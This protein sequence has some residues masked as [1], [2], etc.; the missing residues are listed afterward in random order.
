MKQLSG[1]FL[2]LRSL[3]P[4]TIDNFLCTI[5]FGVSVIFGDCS[6]RVLEMYCSCIRVT[7]LFFIIFFARQSAWL[8]CLGCT[9]VG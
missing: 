6:I 8:V 3:L 7:A 9:S 2:L 4:F 1:N 5:L